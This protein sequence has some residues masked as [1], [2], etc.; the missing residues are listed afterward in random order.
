MP[1]NA[2]HPLSD[3]ALELIAGRFKLLAEPMRLRLLRH[4]ME[5]EHTVTELVT[6]TG[7]GQ[8]NVSKH[9][10]QLADAGML[11]RRKEGLNVFYF[12]ADPTIF[13]L[14][15]LVCRGLEERT[16]RQ[17]ATLAETHPIDRS[18]RRAGSKRQPAR[19]QRQPSASSA[20]EPESP[21][22]VSPVEPPAFEIRFD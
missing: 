22:P 14:C 12:I 9:L 7:A 20:P 2:H 17:S 5:G 6:Q 18:S 15:A 4:L 16:A 8:A 10:T 21:E 13:D 19:K 1:Q 3:K 11:G